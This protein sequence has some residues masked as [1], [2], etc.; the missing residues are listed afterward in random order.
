MRDLLAAS[1]LDQIIPLDRLSHGVLL[2]TLDR[3][4]HAVASSD[5]RRR[6]V[7]DTDCDSVTDDIDV[8]EESCAR[9]RY[10]TLMEL[11]PR[12]QAAVHADK[13]SSANV[14]VLNTTYHGSDM[15]ASVT[16][17]I[18]RVFD[19]Q[20]DMLYGP[21]GTC[22]NPKPGS[23]AF[24]SDSLSSA[25]V[26][27]QNR[28]NAALDTN[29]RNVLRVDSNIT[30]AFENATK[31]YSNTTQIALNKM[32]NDQSS[33]FGAQGKIIA[34]AVAR[35]NGNLSSVSDHVN[36]LQ[37]NLTQFVEDARRDNTGLHNETDPALN[38]LLD[39]V[40][41]LADQLTGVDGIFSDS[42]NALSA[43]VAPLL[44]GQPGRV[45]SDPIN[46]LSTQNLQFI[47]SF[48]DSSIADINNTWDDFNNTIGASSNMTVLSR[49]Q[50]GAHL[51]DAQSA[52]D[53][54]TSDTAAIMDTSV[55][56]T[57]S[58]F[59]TEVRDILALGSD[60]RNVIWATASKLRNVK[61]SLEAMYTSLDGVSGEAA[62]EL[63]KRL[64]GLL[65]SGGEAAA[66]QLRV[67]LQQ[68]N[69]IQNQLGTAS[70]ITNSKLAAAV[71]NIRGMVGSSGLD[72]AG[73]GMDAKQALAANND[74]TQQLSGNAGS[75]ME[76]LISGASE[77]L[78]SA[79][80]R[81][82]AALSNASSVFSSSMSSANSD[83]TSAISGGSASLAAS[84]T[85]ADV[86]SSQE[87]YSVISGLSS[88]GS[89]LEASTRSA[90]RSLDDA[91]NTVFAS[92]SS[93]ESAG[94]NL[95]QASA[96]S[97]NGASG[98]TG[99]ISDFDSGLADQYAR[100]SSTAFSSA[101]NDADRAVAAAGANAKVQASKLLGQ[102]S[103]LQSKADASTTAGTRSFKE[104]ESANDDSM[105]SILDV[106]S[107]S[108]SA[109]QDFQS[110]ANNANSSL[111]QSLGTWFLKALGPASTLSA[112]VSKEAETSQ[113]SLISQT[114]ASLAKHLESFKGTASAL[115]NHVLPDGTAGNVDPTIAESVAS[116]TG[117]NDRVRAA[118]D[119]GR[120][121]LKTV[122]SLVH[123]SDLTEASAIS[124]VKKSMNA[125]VTQ[126][127]KTFTNLSNAVNASFSGLPSQ[128]PD[129]IDGSIR[130]IIADVIKADNQFQTASS[131][132]FARLASTTANESDSS[133]SIVEDLQ[134]TA[135]G[136]QANL[137]DAQASAAQHSAN[138]VNLLSSLADGAGSIASLVS[139]LDRNVSS[140]GNSASQ[141]AASAGMTLQAM[142]SSL[143]SALTAANGSL[144]TASSTTQA[145]ALF[146]GR[147]SQSQASRLL[148]GLQAQAG[149]L[150][151]TATDARSA[152]SEATGEG[153]MN[154]AR[155]EGAL[156]EDSAD[157]NTKISNAI[158]LLERTNTDFAKN[159]TGDKDLVTMQLLMAKRAVRDL[160]SSWTSYTEYETKKFRKMSSTDQDYLRISNQRLDT[161]AQESSANLTASN[162][163]LSTI[164]S[165]IQTAIE[166]YLNFE[167]STSN[168][169]GLLFQVIPALNSS[170][171]ASMSQISNSMK[172]LES[173]DKAIDEDA[174]NYTLQEIS[175]FEASLDQNAQ[176]VIDAASGNLLPAITSR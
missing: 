143:Q 52:L 83:A 48:K 104:A 170:A 131:T 54:Q 77:S 29:W 93:L 169:V 58:H 56:A 149:D 121:Q 45:A 160:L 87:S 124:S 59:R 12:I 70:G 3:N 47:S 88:N 90:G 82:T 51:S 159:V 23:L 35:L 126:T 53:R 50:T 30:S 15:D 14:T 95:D 18:D 176:M 41:Q 17:S 92:L 65:S 32:N 148:Q 125:V 129:G 117:G 22:L 8:I 21:S 43:K 163:G 62:V 46:L 67:V 38:N 152:I 76:A 96:Q 13:A 151:D 162:A 25:L 173:Q 42:I 36:D 111:A 122:Q 79:S 24:G 138:R 73:S 37:G 91:Q 118:I 20:R 106:F 72:H 136:F 100:H 108:D 102:V 135:D 5:G 7:S 11:V 161:Q 164:A 80:D 26:T 4:K 153:A 71:A 156:R 101:G 105:G 31:I 144:S 107:A 174:R 9:Y 115:V 157:R 94:N 39:S 81:N 112:D 154:L 34:N 158:Q 40:D 44:S 127:E 99:S 2:E 10:G 114:D 63:K 172:S 137:S 119:S 6:T 74:Y 123:A 146:N 69:S 171:Q 49:Q 103:G 165:D 116:V 140:T 98:L 19:E 130:Q 33:L 145:Q 139:L 155:I 78:L 61:S 147:L 85:A 133:S 64:S 1:L 150:H 134:S 132:A 128:F 66:N 97:A 84:A 68:F 27:V 89:L 110:A 16:Y 55:N 120:E 60:A 142:I 113:A 168:Q 75:S 175:N 167:N 109:I 141:G 166:E 57:A 28:L 86:Q